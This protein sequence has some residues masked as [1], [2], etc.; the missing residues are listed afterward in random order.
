MAKT[1]LLVEDEQLIKDMYQK[2]FQERGYEVAVA[3]DGEQALQR[4]LT[5]PTK[6]D[7]VLLDIMMPKLDGISVLRRLKAA[8]SSAKTV[9]VFLLTNLGMDTLIKEA[10]SLG[11][12]Q[13]FVKANY[14][15]NQIVDEIDQYFKRKEGQTAP[16]SSES[17]TPASATPTGSTPSS[18]AEVKPEP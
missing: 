13:F 8:D 11:A 4:L 1:I 17:T 3:E 9:P 5:E 15:P 18:T 10:L 2:V 12:E 6:Y 7:L 14:L 16:P